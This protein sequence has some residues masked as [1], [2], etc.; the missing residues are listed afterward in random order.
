VT[1]DLV[2]GLA[3]I[4]PT[5]EVF[6]A[7]CLAAAA[8]GGKRLRPAFLYGAWRAFAPEDEPSSAAI[9]VA[10]AVETLHAAILVH[11][12]VIDASDLRR[13]RPSVRAA[14]AEHH[15]SAALSGP[16]AVFGDHTAVLLGDLLWGLA[17]DMLVDAVKAVPGAHADE[18]T[19]HF[20]TMRTEVIAGQL[21]EL[22]GQAARDFAADTAAKIVRYKTT[23]YTVA[24][25]MNLGFALANAPEHG[26]SLLRRYAE[27]TGAAFQL[28]DDLAD[29]FA[30]T[31]H[32]GKRNG[33]DVRSAK[34]TLLMQLALE[35]AGPSQRQVLSATL[36]QPNAE[37]AQIEEVKDIV[38]ATEAARSVCARIGALADDARE[39]LTETVTEY[40]AAVVA[41]LEELLAPC[42]DVSFVP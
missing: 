19:R 35:A 31:Q 30:D 2:A 15:R 7:Q 40:P 25:P 37:D 1:G 23:A 4:D 5:L 39:A 24:R 41:P 13:N 14:L 6:A 22:R 10:A 17:Q 3:G 16:A 18:V 34:P 20:R 33:D 42:T 29:L 8:D 9:G 12:D 28:R 36:G 26:V 11:D 32:S 21:L 27:A 38:V